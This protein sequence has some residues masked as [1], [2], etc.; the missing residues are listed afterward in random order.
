MEPSVVPYKNRE[1][2]ANDLEH[3][4]KKAEL[5]EREQK[6]GFPLLHAQALVTICGAL[7]NLMHTFVVNWLTNYPTAKQVKAVR[8]IKL[9]IWRYDSLDAEELNEYI[10][11]TLRRDLNVPM[12]QGVSQF[13]ALLEPFGLSGGVTKIVRDDIYEMYNV[14]NVLVHRRGKADTK[15]IEACP[16]L[17]YSLGD[18]VVVKHRR[19]GEYSHHAA[20]YAF[21]VLQRIAL[22]VGIDPSSDRY[23][24]NRI[25]P[26]PE[27][28]K[29]SIS[30]ISR[31]IEGETD[32]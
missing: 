6:N 1:F 15:L 10:F 31:T 12:R 23:D 17:G 24:P 21:E 22:K 20:R 30:E 25:W 18:T 11:E 5:A 7:E 19:F 8:E 16:A 3:A 9:E 26:L 13:E 32:V 14:R 28:Q 27:Q 29:Q 2:T 4:R